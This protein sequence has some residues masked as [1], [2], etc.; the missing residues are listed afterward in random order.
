MALASIH[1]GWYA[2]KQRNQTNPKHMLNFKA[3]QKKEAYSVMFIRKNA[4][5]IQTHAFWHLTNP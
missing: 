3:R 5:E 4:E 2:I 1:A